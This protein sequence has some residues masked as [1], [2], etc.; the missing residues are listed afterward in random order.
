MWVESLSEE[1]KR[2]A[3]K[4]K[5][6]FEFLPIIDLRFRCRIDD[7]VVSYRLKPATPTQQLLEYSG[8]LVEEIKKAGERRRERIWIAR[9]T[10]LR[11]TLNLWG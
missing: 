2:L 5:V 10:T 6:S 1:L 9:E 3:Q 11:R 8:Q 4:E 7:N